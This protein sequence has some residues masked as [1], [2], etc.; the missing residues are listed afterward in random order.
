MRAAEFFAAVETA[1]I[2]QASCAQGFAESDGSGGGCAVS[3][4]ACIQCDMSIPCAAAA[5]LPPCG[6]AVCAAAQPIWRL[7][8]AQERSQAEDQDDTVRRRATRNPAMGLLADTG[9][10]LAC[11][12]LADYP[13]PIP[14]EIMI[15]G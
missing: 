9:E 1:M 4:A 8:S 2:R 11:P 12:R 3:P 14:S 13:F 15:T 7:F 5:S 10:I 6:R